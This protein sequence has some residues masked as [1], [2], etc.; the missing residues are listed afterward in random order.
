MK[1][2]RKTTLEERI[3]ITKD[4]IA[5]GYDYG[6]IALKYDVGYQ[7]VY[8]WV[9]KF[10]KL[11]NAGLEDRRGQRKLDQVPRTPEEDAQIEIARL[12]HENYMLRM[13][14]DLLIKLEELERRD[15]FRK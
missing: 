11:G 8:T 9:K 3:Q 2:S 1:K 15:A 14:R 13:E 12:K 10:T 6:G 4:C 7:Q 5:S